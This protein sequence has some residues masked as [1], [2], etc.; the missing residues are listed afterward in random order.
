MK[1]I[2]ALIL[3]AALLLAAAPAFAAGMQD[4]PQL[5]VKGISTVTSRH[6]DVP[7]YTGPDPDWYYRTASGKACVEFGQEVAIYGEESGYLLIR[8][9]TTRFGEWI[10]RFSFVPV[11]NVNG[12]WQYDPIWLEYIPIAIEGDATLVDDPDTT[13]SGY[14]TIE[15]DRDFNVAALARIEIDGDTWVY[16]EAE[17]YSSVDDEWMMVRGFVLWY[18]VI[19]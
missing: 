7:V 4:L 5:W 13:R 9:A 8:Y 19:F 16:F 2:T 3:A 10:H 6:S 1:K 11:T 15:I 14:N 12:G 17:G 18:D